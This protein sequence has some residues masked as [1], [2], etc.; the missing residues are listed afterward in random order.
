ML[1]RRAVDRSFSASSSAGAIGGLGCFM[2]VLYDTQ[3]V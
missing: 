3:M 1:P 2:R